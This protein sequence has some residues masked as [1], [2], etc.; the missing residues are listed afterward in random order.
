VVR[1]GETLSGFAA[2]KLKVRF[3]IEPS[4]IL[5]VLLIVIYEVNRF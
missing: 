4:G 1:L 2:K 3:K 5:S